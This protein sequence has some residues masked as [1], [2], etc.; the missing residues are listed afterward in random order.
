ML[1]FVSH[2]L[3]S[4]SLT[5]FFIMYLLINFI[6]TFHN[7]NAYI[8][9]YSFPKNYYSYIRIPLLNIIMLFM[10]MPYNNISLFIMKTI[11][12]LIPSFYNNFYL[13]FGISFEIFSIL[14]F[15]IFSLI[16]FIKV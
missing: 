5:N 2:T 16:I 7:P 11:L 14:E 6:K 1:R 15:S 4:R 12:N 3:I 9:I 13:I 10:K 8:S